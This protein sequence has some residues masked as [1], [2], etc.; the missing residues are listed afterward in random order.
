MS[1]Q[2][3]DIAVGTVRVIAARKTRNECRARR[4][5]PVSDPPSSHARYSDRRQTDDM[6]IYA[7]ARYHMRFLYD[8]GQETGDVV[9]VYST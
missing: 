8:D 3:H 4:F 2:N 5:R 7:A 9:I 6:V 1:W